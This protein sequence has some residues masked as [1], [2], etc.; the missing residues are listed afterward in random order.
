MGGRRARS[1][2]EIVG[3]G[4]SSSGFNS[5]MDGADPT[6]MAASSAALVADSDRITDIIYHVSRLSDVVRKLV[7][8]GRDLSY[9]E[10]EALARKEW[11]RIKTR[12]NLPDDPI[13]TKAVI[14]GV[15]KA[16]GRGGR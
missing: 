11:S 2:S 13:V 9:D 16:L 6:A 12:E 4:L 15:T 5:A 14:A 3:T 8:S 10:R 1:L 7:E